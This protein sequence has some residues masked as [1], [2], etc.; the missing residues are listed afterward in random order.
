MGIKNI[1]TIAKEEIDAELFWLDLN[2]YTLEDGRTG[3]FLTLSRARVYSEGDNKILDRPKRST[4][5]LKAVP[6]LATIL[7]DLKV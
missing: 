3:R 7:K 5:S 2:E 4:I 1:R 6:W